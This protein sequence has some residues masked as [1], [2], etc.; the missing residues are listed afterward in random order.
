VFVD[1]I[2][3]LVGDV[4]ADALAPLAEQADLGGRDVVLD[5]LRDDADV[6][7]PLLE[8]YKRIVYETSEG[9]KH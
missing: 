4:V 2:D 8:L 7:P 6:L 5:E 3:D 9:V 1:V